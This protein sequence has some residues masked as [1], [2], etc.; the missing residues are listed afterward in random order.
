MTIQSIFSDFKSIV[1]DSEK[2]TFLQTLQTL[3]LPYDI[4]YETLITFYHN[5]NK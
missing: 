5:R 1:T 4:R 2:V 3:N